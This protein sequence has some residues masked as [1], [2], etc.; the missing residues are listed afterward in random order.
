M[1]FK[2]MCQPKSR[3]Y[4]PEVA[5][6]LKDS[7]KGDEE[8]D[9]KNVNVPGKKKGTGRKAG[10]KRKRKSGKDKGKD[11]GKGGK[12]GR[13]GR[14]RK[15]KAAQDDSDEDEEDGEDLFEDEE[16]NSCLFQSMPV[17]FS[18]YLNDIQHNH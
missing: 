8:T 3:H 7:G 15:R 4:Q 18:G 6:A 13:G 11:R 17:G 16:P 14:G 12:G 1:M 9:G 10:K 2:L 5:K